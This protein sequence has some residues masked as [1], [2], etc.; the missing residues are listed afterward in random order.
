MKIELED[1]SDLDHYIICHKCHTVHEKVAIEDGSK[2]LCS[3]CKMVLYRHDTRLIEHGLALSVTG[4]IFFI[5]AN[6]FP[7]VKIEILGAESYITIVS[8]ISSLMSSGYYIVA[9]FL[10]YLIVIFPVMIFSLYILLFAL[11]KLKRGEGLVKNILILLAQIEP[12]QM[13]D[14]FVV[15]I[16]V[17]IVKL[18]GIATIHMG[19]SFWTLFAF[20]LIDIYMT[21]NIHLGELW[22][23]KQN[24]YHDKNRGLS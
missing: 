20:V 19:T 24:L 14:I 6:L 13:S 5:L 10:L 21:R 12:W 15:S 17:S 18:F 4:L 23:L 1:E 16:L 3:V 9:L 11:L 7:L 22:T 8:M 2:A